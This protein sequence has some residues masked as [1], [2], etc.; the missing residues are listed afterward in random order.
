MYFAKEGLFFNF[1]FWGG[2][3]L[4]ELIF[5]ILRYVSCFKKN[6]DPLS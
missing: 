6:H 1:F 2:E 5:G 4:G 3:G